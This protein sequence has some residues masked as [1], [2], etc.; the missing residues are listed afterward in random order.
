L[1]RD[2]RA[3]DEPAAPAPV[4]RKGRIKQGVCTGVFRGLKLTDDEMCREVVR[5]GGHGIDL[6]PPEKFAVLKNT[7]S[8][9]R[10]SRFRPA[11]PR[12]A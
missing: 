12:R 8:P 7:G 11:R 1:G 9:A 10:W 4:R 5:L 6:Q 2:L 3:A